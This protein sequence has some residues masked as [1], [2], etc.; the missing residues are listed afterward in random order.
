MYKIFKRGFDLTSATLLFLAIS[1]F[2]LV[3]M[4]LVRIKHGS[5]I[6]NKK[7][8]TGKDFKPFMLMKFRTM[9][10]ATDSDGN[11]LPDNKILYDLLILILHF[12][13]QLF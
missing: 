2:F 12:P 1:P 13:P 10:N 6:K 7:K 9:T 5:P 3:L 4:L 11:L 8:R